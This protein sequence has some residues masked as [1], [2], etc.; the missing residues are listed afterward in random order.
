MQAP[1]VV[2]KFVTA[3]NEPDKAKRPGLIADA[4][5]AAYVLIAP[6]LSAKPGALKVRSIVDEFLP[7]I[8]ARFAE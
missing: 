8:A 3:C 6:L 5:V 4:I 7:Q 1:G 2:L